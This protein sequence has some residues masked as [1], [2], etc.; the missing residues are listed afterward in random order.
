MY[1][2]VPDW[3]VQKWDFSICTGSWLGLWKSSPTGKRQSQSCYSEWWLPGESG[4]RSHSSAG[5]DWL[6]LLFWSRNPDRSWLSVGR[7]RVNK[8]LW[9]GWTALRKGWIQS[10]AANRLGTDERDTRDTLE[11]AGP[12]I[13]GTRKTD[14]HLLYICIDTFSLCSL[15]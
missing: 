5:Q 3:A 13:N 12:Q 9:P 2:W 14:M 10:L 15:E 11:L 4:L 1:Q 7:C 8:H 6:V